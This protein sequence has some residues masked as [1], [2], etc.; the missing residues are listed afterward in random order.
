MNYTKA[1]KRAWETTWRYRALWIFGVILAL[2]TIS[3]S[4]AAS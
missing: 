3:W 2:T 1:L 4:T